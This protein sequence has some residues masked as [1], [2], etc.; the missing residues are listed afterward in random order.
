MNKLDQTLKTKCRQCQ[1]EI[2]K[3]KWLSCHKK[4]NRQIIYFCRIYC[5]KKL[6]LPQRLQLNI[7]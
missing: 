6:M 3:I 5:M 4:G 2:P 1:K 7:N